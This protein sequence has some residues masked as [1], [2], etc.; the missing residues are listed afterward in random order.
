MSSA[1]GIAWLG[2]ILM[3]INFDEFKFVRFHEIKLINLLDLLFSYIKT[4]YLSY[5]L[6]ASIKKEA[7]N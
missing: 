5:I 6:L 2:K 4:T 1:H 3:P 7:F